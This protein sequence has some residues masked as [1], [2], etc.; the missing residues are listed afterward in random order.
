MVSWTLE[1]EKVNIS[2][3]PKGFPFFLEHLNSLFDVDCLMK[4]FIL[5]TVYVFVAQF[6]T[7]LQLQAL[8]S[9]LYMT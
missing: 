7:F 5:K 3:S 2:K 4:L 6:A 9:V 1:Y 8:K